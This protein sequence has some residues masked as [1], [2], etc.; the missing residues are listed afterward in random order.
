M[1]F[2]FTSPLWEW[3]SQGASWFFVT[4]PEEASEDLREIPRMPRGFG[5]IKVRVT[6]G[7]TS[8]LT[9]VFPDSRTGGHW[10]PIKKAVRVA[11]GLEDGEP[12]AVRLELVE[13]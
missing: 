1:R 11:E 10:L 7:G 2:E 8:W 12:V 6:V 5:A 4:L 13:L 3:S 9:S